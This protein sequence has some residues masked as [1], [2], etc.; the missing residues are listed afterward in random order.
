MSASGKGKHGGASK[1]QHKV[2]HIHRARKGPRCP[3]CGRRMKVA[4]VPVCQF[5]SVV[6]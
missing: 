5:E 4:E 2:K 6:P 1:V 3:K